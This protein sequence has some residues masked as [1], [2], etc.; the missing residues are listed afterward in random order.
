M[1]VARGGPLEGDE[2]GAIMNG[3]SAF[4]R[5]TPQSDLSPPTMWGHSEKSAICILEEGLQNP[6]QPAPWSWTSNMHIWETKISVVNKLPS[7]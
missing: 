7:L 1:V 5:E 2:G 4:V 3:I 6:N